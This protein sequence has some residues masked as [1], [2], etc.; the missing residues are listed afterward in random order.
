MKNKLKFLIKQSLKKKV[1]TKWF[2]AVN[3]ILCILIVA[4]ANIDRLI[5]AFGGDFNKDTT[6]YVKDNVGVY[7]YLEPLFNETTKTVEDLK[8][9]KVEKTDKSLKELK[10]NI[11]DTDNIIVEINSS[12]TNYISSTITTYDALDT[13]SYQLLSN[14]LN[15]T[16]E[17]FVIGK[18]GLTE[19]EIIALKSNIEITKKTTNPDLKDNAKA[20]DIISSGLII[21]FI[22]PFFIFITLLVQM[23]GA[24]INEEKSTKSM[25]IIISNVPPKYHFIAKIS[26]SSLFVII[27][28]ALLFSYT[29][30]AMLVRNLIGGLFGSGIV[31]SNVS[32]YLKDIINL[33][34]D[35]GI[36]DLLI[37]GLPFIILL[38][39]VN[40][41]AYAIIAGVLA[42]MTT[43]IEDYQ[44]LQSP[45]MIIM[46]MGYF[47][48]IMAST[49]DGSI[50]IK[51]V[52]FIPLLSALVAPVIYLL[53]QTTIIELIISLIICMITVAILYIYG[54]KI[55]KVGILN[56]SSSNLW[57]K[58]LKSLKE[59]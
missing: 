34:K 17:A 32:K 24:E 19:N 7:D 4:M 18:L 56:Y 3:I 52:S 43:N 29:I 1:G 44:Q 2:K 13:I 33:L 9:Y 47:I 49:F 21:L 27:Q 57:K 26:A 42:S 39:I 51:I 41:L 6:V 50:F 59:K 53:G 48:A 20:K 58:I 46:M 30:L 16:K 35:S 8:N 55:Y 38:F 28:G 45:I 54:L 11:K 25:E 37:K 14:V 23:L 31:S 36:I 5:T 12:D 40:I 10:K 22:V 15:Q